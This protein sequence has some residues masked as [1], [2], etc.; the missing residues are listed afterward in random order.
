MRAEEGLSLGAALAI[1]AGGEPDG[2]GPASVELLQGA[3]AAVVLLKNM[4]R[5]HGWLW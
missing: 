5:S 4:R 3:V 1:T 2:K